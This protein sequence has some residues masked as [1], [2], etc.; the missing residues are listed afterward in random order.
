[1]VKPK[2]TG[3]PIQMDASNVSERATIENDV[4]DPVP[5][6]HNA[7]E[8]GDGHESGNGEGVSL[9]NDESDDNDSVFSPQYSLIDTAPWTLD[10]FDAFVINAW[11]SGLSFDYDSDSLIDRN[12]EAMVHSATSRGAATA[13][14]RL[15]SRA[16]SIE[17]ASV[18]E[19]MLNDPSKSACSIC[20]DEFSHIGQQVG[21]TSCG[22]YFHASCIETWLTNHISCPNCRKLLF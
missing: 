21:E 2:F 10:V 16:Q 11:A 7:R 1:M 18:D 3:L 6:G 19:S 20:L 4:T 15:S 13:A 17:E 5:L 8:T 22:H 14:R 9:R 12:L